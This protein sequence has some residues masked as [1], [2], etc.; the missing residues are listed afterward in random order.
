LNSSKEHNVPGREEVHVWL[1]KLNKPGRSDF[2][3]AEFILDASEEEQAGRFRFSRGRLHYR[4]TRTLVRRLLSYY[5]PVVDPA[6]WR[7]TRNDFGKPRIAEPD[8]PVPCF[9]NLSH[10]GDRIVLAVCGNPAIGVD[11]EKIDRDRNVLTIARRF[12]PAVEVQKLEDLTPEARLMRFYQLWTLKEAYSKACGEGLVSSLGQLEL[13][14]REAG[15]I[16]VKLNPG[17]A[18]Q[19]AAWK[20]WL[21]DDEDGP[22]AV[23][24]H[25]P[26]SAQSAQIQWREL[27]KLDGFAG[28]DEAHLKLLGRS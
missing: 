3:A 28:S 23:A 24:L 4:L 25:S 12:F 6:A 16:G 1:M 21:Y 2:S 19:A 13:C 7:F 22:L 5:F 20:L 18:Q 17:T 26:Q 9:F 14:F 15:K 8:L 10:S 11:V 27:R